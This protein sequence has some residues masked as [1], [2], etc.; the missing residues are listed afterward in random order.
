MTASIPTAILA[1]HGTRIA[2]LYA[3]ARAIDQNWRKFQ[4]GEMRLEGQIALTRLYERFSTNRTTV[5]MMQETL[6]IMVAR[7]WA[8]IRVE[9]GRAAA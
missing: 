7:E 5:G 3:G 6:R 8:R 9:C 2:R 4:R 1:R